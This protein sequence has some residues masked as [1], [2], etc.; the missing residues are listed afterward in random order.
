MDNKK[1]QGTSNTGKKKALIF[2]YK[3]PLTLAGFITEGGKILPSRI[4]GLSHKRQKALK[5]SIKKA[6]RLSLLPIGT[7]AYDSFGKIESISKKPFS[8]D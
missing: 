8:I 3:D 7:I 4:N 5:N 6:R 1:T 2:D